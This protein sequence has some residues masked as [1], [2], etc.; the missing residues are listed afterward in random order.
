MNDK[1]AKTKHQVVIIFHAR[2][3]EKKTGDPFWGL[4]VFS[5][6]MRQGA[7]LDPRLFILLSAQDVAIKKYLRNL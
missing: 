3:I 2:K 5:V 7:V 4:I 1:G 6:G